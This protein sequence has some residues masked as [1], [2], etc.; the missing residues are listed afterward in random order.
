M[1]IAEIEQAIAENNAY[2]DQ[3]QKSFDEWQNAI[4]RMAIDIGRMEKAIYLQLWGV[5]A[6]YPFQFQTEEAAEQSLRDL[7]E[8]DRQYRLDQMERGAQLY[9]CINTKK[10][11]L[12]A[13]LEEARIASRQTVHSL[14][15]AVA[16]ESNIIKQAAWAS[17]QQTSLF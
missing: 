10:K 17:L 13:A 3:L 4:F 6:E 12:H 15:A 5:F 1:T 8:R 11:N 9:Y 7:C 14:T 2:I 16:N